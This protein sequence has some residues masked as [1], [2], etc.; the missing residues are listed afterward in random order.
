MGIKNKITNFVK[1]QNALGKQLKEDR[2][3]GTGNSYDTY[4]AIS[5]RHPH[6]K[7]MFKPQGGG[8]SW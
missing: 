2:A 5:K 4:S 1:Y 8:G 3:N 7:K 6:I